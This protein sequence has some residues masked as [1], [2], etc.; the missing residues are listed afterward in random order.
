MLIMIVL[1]TDYGQGSPYVAQI[2]AVLHQHLKRPVIIDLMHEAPVHQPMLSSYLLA[3]W[4]S[5]FESGSVFL[6]VVDP[7]VGDRKQ[8]AAVVV[9]DGKWFV[10]PDNG[11]L[12]M[13]A[14]QARKVRWWDIHWRPK[15]LSNTFHGRDLYA[16]L[17]C[18]L[19][20]REPLPGAEEVPV[21]ARLKPF[22]EA[23]LPQVLFID[24]FGNAMT[25]LDFSRA[26]QNQTLIIENSGQRLS[27]ARTFS[28]VPPGKGFWY[29]NS[30][31]KVEIAVNR[32]HAAEKLNLHLGDHV[33][34]SQ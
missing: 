30:S 16:R 18:K 31:G 21:T 20:A 22:W 3:A 27:Y 29:G 26:D 2:K 14:S 19:I 17:V 5:S 12:N 10:G 13:V 33:R 9:A 23:Q 11:L 1:F 15:D 25:G 28:S 8:R 7:D 6:A 24:R 4:S 34:F 32:G